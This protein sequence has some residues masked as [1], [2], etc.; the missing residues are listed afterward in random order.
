[1]NQLDTTSK[2]RV[3]FMLW[4]ENNDAANKNKSP[5]LYLY[6]SSL[7]LFLFYPHSLS[8]SFRELMHGEESLQEK[9]KKKVFVSTAMLLF[10]M[11]LARTTLWLFPLKY[12]FA[13]VYKTLF[14]ILSVS[15]F[16]LRLLFG[17]NKLQN[18]N[19]FSAFAIIRRARK[20]ETPIS[21]YTYVFQP[22]VGG[23]RYA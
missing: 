5:A 9:K 8:F 17:N 7:S 3:Y 22:F 13:A 18:Y 20:K 2:Q 21:I 1:M 19:L 6:I 14:Q 12:A 23:S 10:L 16:K 15:A 4:Y 11:L